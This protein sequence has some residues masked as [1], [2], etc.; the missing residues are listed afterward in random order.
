MVQIKEMVLNKTPEDYV[1]NST[2]W[3]GPILIAWIEKQYNV[4]FKKAQ[5]HNVLKGQVKECKKVSCN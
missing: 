1:I 3:T 4:S 5:I 2:T